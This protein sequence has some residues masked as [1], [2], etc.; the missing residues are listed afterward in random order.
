MCFITSFLLVNNSLTELV[1]MTGSLQVPLH[2][3]LAL[4][5]CLATTELTSSPTNATGDVDC[6]L[7]L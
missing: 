5:V 1:V 6:A 4:G 2:L 7:F 3:L